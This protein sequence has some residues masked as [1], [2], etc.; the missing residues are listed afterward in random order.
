MYDSSIFISLLRIVFNGSKN[1]RKFFV[2]RQQLLL[3]RWRLKLMWPSNHWPNTSQ[4]LCRCLFP[5]LKFYPFDFYT[6]YRLRLWN[7]PFGAQIPGSLVF[8]SWPQPELSHQWSRSQHGWGYAV[9]Q[10]RC[11][12][13]L[14]QQI[15]RIYSNCIQACRKHFTASYLSQLS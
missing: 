12:L 10:V 14:D 8:K 13:F 15:E 7:A 1:S 9:L 6:I 2:W 11:N 4:T 5:V 3:T